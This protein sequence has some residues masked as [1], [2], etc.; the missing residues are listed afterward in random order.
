MTDPLKALAAELRAKATAM[1]T[2]SDAQRDERRAAYCDGKAMALRYAADRLD[3]IAGAT[4][5]PYRSSENFPSGFSPSDIQCP[6][7]AEA[8]E[9]PAPPVKDGIRALVEK[10]KE[11]SSTDPAP[12]DTVGDANRAYGECAAELEQEIQRIDAV[13]AR[14][15]RAEAENAKLIQII[16]LAGE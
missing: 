2:E 11:K 13:E 10:W 4:E 16:A 8:G 6:V 12:W 1:Q 5:P 14:A 7:R 9:G 3:Q 15:D